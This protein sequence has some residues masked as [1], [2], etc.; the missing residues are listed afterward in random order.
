MAIL[1]IFVCFFVWWYLTPLSTIFQ[2]YS[3]GQF[4]WWR[5]PAGGPGENHWQTLSHNVVH[6]AL[7]EIRTHNISGDTLYNW[8]IVESGVKYHQTKKQTKIY[9]MAICYDFTCRKEYIL[10]WF[11]VPVIRGTE[12]HLLQEYVHILMMFSLS[13]RGKRH[14]SGFYLKEGVQN[15]ISCRNKYMLSWF[16]LWEGQM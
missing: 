6:L 14:F 7:I 1:Y 10:S 12:C 9:N 2:L 4:Y 16:F 5:K 11:S 13:S 15:V 3:G 8:N